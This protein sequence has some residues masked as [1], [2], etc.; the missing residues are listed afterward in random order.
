MLKTKIVSS[1]EKIFADDRIEQYATLEKIS[2]LQ[3]ERL[4]LQ[5]LSTYRPTKDT[6]VH[7]RV[8][9][10]PLQMQGD[11]APYATLRDV[12]QVPV[13]LPCYPDSRD[14]NFLR[15]T[16]GLYPDLL[17]PLQYKGSMTVQPD[18][19][20]AVWIEINVPADLAAGEYTLSLSLSDEKF[21]ESES[22]VCVEVIGARLPADE[23][24]LT[25]WFHCDCLANYYGVEV[26]SERHWEIVENFV[27]IAV[28]NGINLL[29]TPVFTPP[30]DTTVGGERR[31]TQLVGVERNNGEYRFDF[32]LLDRWVDMCDRQGI[33]YLEIS[34]FFTQWGAEHAPK[35]M[36][37][38]DGEYKRLFGWETAAAGEEYSTFLRTFLKEFLAH[39]KRRGDDKRCFFHISDEPSFTKHRES[40]EAA[41]AV[42]ADLLEGYVMMDA[43][44]NIQFYETG[45]VQ[46]PIPASNH[47][48]PFI[49]AGVP[50][51]WTYYC[52]GQQL[53]VSNRFVAMPAWR[54]RSIGMQFYKYDIAGFLQWG[55]NFYN[56]QVSDSPIDP[57]LELSGNYA[58]PA[59]DAFSVYPAPDGTAYESTRIIVFHEALQDRKAMKLCEQYYG[60]EAVVSAI[61]EVFGKS[62]TFATCA[63]SAEMMLRVREKINAMIKKAISK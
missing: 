34:H 7:Y 41:R 25:Q 21:G 22:H 28:K 12:R 46:T 6:A 35:V 39:M 54:N 18:A 16:P 62:I 31:T 33:K 48:D 37:T 11:L 20:C 5:F 10:I 3:G 32:T 27:K 36:A 49:E 42:V 55:Y 44:S 19:L 8:A 56:N 38:V 2:V 45:L 14:D 23:I 43:L 40:Y 30:L 26:W 15:T 17:T 13:T 52:C 9:R 51:L 29:L 53:D 63:K 58:F 24:Y 1:Q 47:I 61:E 57:Y 50:N 4:S 59:G 60:K